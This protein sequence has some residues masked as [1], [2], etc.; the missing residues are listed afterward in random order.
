M[1]GNGTVHVPARIRRA[2]GLKDGDL[3]L[4]TVEENRRIVIVKAD[5]RG[6]E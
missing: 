6:V 1:Y 5:V 3:V 2:V 4:W